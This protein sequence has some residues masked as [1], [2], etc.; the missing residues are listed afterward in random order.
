MPWPKRKREHVK[1]PGEMPPHDWHAGI[2]VAIV[3]AYARSRP[4][5][6]IEIGVD[7][8]HTVLDVWEVAS[9]VIAVDITFDNLIVPLPD[10]V[11]QYEMKSDKF[12]ATWNA[13]RGRLVDVI[14]VDGDHN[15]D[16]AWRDINNALN[17]ITLDGVVIV[18]DTHPQHQKFTYWCG[19]V[20]QVLE[21]LKYTGWQYF[22]LPVFPGLTFISHQHRPFFNRD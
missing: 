9:T 17:A 18:H 14:F 19:T 11:I 20:Y 16:Q 13:D 10:S 7:Q 1:P 21:E 12:F 6:Y 2:I 22:T 5:T 15:F 8:G 3:K 4:V